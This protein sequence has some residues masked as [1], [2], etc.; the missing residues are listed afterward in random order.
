MRLVSYSDG[1]AIRVGVDH[2]DGVFE[3]SF[4]SMLDVISGG[5]ETVEAV[6][7][8]AERGSPVT[9]DRIH[10][11]LTNPPKILGSGINYLSHMEEEPGAKLPDEPHWF[12]KLPSSIIGPHDAI[13]LPR[14]DFYVDYEVELGVVIGRSARWVSADDALD[15]VFGYTVINDV[16]SRAVQFK[17]NQEDIGKSLDTFCPIGP[18]IVTADEI[19]DP[20]ALHIRSFVNGEAR[21]SE[22]TSAM[23]FSVAEIIE[24]LSMLFTLEPGTILSTGTPARC[25]TFLQPP[26]FLKPGDVV[27][28]AEDT[29]G[30]LTNDVKLAER[31]IP[32]PFWTVGTRMQPANMG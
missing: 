7:R 5:A 11:P 17:D 21:Q 3:T 28:V 10:A 4:K 8:E 20:Q 23:R 30:E 32:A 1:G 12:S 19:P 13:E 26:Q 22:P 29:I 27:T 16:T 25:G 2:P 31:E 24:Y 9:P 6:R 14:A 18:C 15:H